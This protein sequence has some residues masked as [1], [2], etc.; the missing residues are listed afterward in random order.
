M[1]SSKVPSW[2]MNCLPEDPAAKVLQLVWRAGNE[3]FWQHVRYDM[4]LS[5][6]IFS[7]LLYHPGKQ[8]FCT[9]EELGTCSQYSEN[10]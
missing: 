3:M 10:I 4:Y 1:P 2:Q 5:D 9:P 6:V 8:L 7:P